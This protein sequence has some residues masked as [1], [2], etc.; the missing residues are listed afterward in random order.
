MSERDMAKLLALIEK[1]LGGGWI[2]AAEWLRNLPLNSVEA[3]EERLLRGD[4]AG[5]VAEVE[6]AAL[7]FA[8]E[9]Q[10]AFTT[11][12]RKAAEWLDAQPALKDKLIRFDASGS[13]VVDIARRNQLELVVG[14]KDERNQIARQITQ[15]AMVDGYANN[16][17]QVAQRFRESI[18][19]TAYQQTHVENYRRALE[20]GDWDNALGRELTTARDD[21]MVAGVARRPTGNSLTPKQVDDAVERYRQNYI[22]YR[23]ETIARTEAARNV[24]A[25]IQESM[26]QAIDRGDLK[27]ENL[28]RE[29]IAGPRTLLAR[30]SHQRMDGKM[31]AFGEKFTLPSGAK[32]DYPGD[33]NAPVS[34]LANCRCTYATTLAGI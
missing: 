21:R 12:G 23:A 17:R 25:G 31:V 8:A 1:H 16:P 3:I 7:K 29:W 5:I 20:R 24:H 15:R 4:I 22:T 14:F 10:S 27:A 26:R 11:A 34:E 19:L 13:R 6:A 9:T 28:V 32:M 30:D 2:D 33:P 18:G